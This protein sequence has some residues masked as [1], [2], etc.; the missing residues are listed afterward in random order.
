MTQDHDCLHRFFF[1]DANVRGVI[2]Q[3]RDTWQQIA[4]RDDYPTEV[5]QWLAQVAAATALFAGDVKVDGS[6]SVHL[7]SASALRLV[8][9]EC[10]SQGDMRGVARWDTFDAIP[11]VPD[12]LRGAA[13]IL[14]LTVM[15]ANGEPKWQGMVPLEGNSLAAAFESYFNRSEQLPTSLF[16]AF[17]G[18]SCAGLLLQEVPA[19]GGIARERDAAMYEYAR[20]MAATIESDELL[21]LSPHEILRRLFHEETLRLLDAQPIRFQCRCSRDRAIGILRSIGPEETA[22]ALAESGERVTVTC[23]FCNGQYSFDAIDIQQM[24]SGLD[25]DAAVTRH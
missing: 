9:A 8:F 7:K 10:S 21:N 25:Q 1:E 17:D 16:F 22:A 24:F 11:A 18:K 23:E 15:R 12:D 20:T 3:L 4:H 13:G 2:V 6:V 19:E 14:A 5:R